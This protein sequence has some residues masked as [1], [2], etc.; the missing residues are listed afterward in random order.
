[1][2]EKNQDKR[3]VFM[4]T[5][6]KFVKNFNNLTNAIQE[7]DIQYKNRLSSVEKKIKFSLI[8]AGLSLFLVL[9]GIAILVISL[10]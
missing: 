3:P 2:N 10:W 5:F 8:A 1:M 4:G 9:T 7:S 6:S